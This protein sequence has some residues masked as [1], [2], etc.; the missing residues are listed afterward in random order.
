MV[1]C[2]VWLLAQGAQLPNRGVVPRSAAPGGWEHFAWALVALT[3]LGTVLWAARSFMASEQSQKAQAV[4]RLFGSLCTAH[5]L[6]WSDRQLLRRLARARAVDNPS[7]LFVE[8]RHFD[9]ASLSEPLKAQAARL[10]QLRQL[11][12]GK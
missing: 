2:F 12:F 11:L 3:I 5:G 1:A 4:R 10:S 9:G 6:S 7:K 8:P